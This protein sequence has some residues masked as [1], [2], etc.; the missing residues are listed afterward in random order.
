MI[1]VADLPAVREQFERTAAAAKEP[2]VEPSLQTEACAGAA[3]VFNVAELPAVKAH[4]AAAAAES[5]SATPAQME[6]GAKGSEKA[7]A[8]K[9]SEIIQSIADG[10]RIHARLWRRPGRCAVWA[11]HKCTGDQ[12]TCPFRR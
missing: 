12:E 10:E 3:G 9:C 2:P 8:I 7:K 5:T 4:F 6:D 1:N 11:E